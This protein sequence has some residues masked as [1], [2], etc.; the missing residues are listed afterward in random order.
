MQLTQS[1][2]SSSSDTV[3]DGEE[4]GRNDDVGGPAGGGEEGGAHAAKLEREEL[5]RV[6]GDVSESG[7]VRSDEVDHHH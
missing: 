5:V 4:G 6:P 1:E 2:S 3:H 7:S